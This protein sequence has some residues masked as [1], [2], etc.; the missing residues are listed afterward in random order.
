MG[1]LEIYHL[2]FVM[3][4]KHTLIDVSPMKCIVICFMALNIVYF[5]VWAIKP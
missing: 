5:G 4:V 3:P 2:M 1:N